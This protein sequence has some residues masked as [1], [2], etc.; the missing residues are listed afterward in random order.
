MDDLRTT[1]G[2]ANINTPK[3]TFDGPTRDYTINTNDQ[4]QKADDYR[5]IIVAY[6]NGAPVYLSRRSG[7]RS[8]APEDQQAPE[9]GRIRP[10]RSC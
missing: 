1:I 3:G 8:T 2:N 4:L 6:N 10:R 5:N 9:L 7:G